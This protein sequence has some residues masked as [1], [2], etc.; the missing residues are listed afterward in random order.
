M[1]ATNVGAELRQYLTFSLAGEEYAVGILE[2]KE[3][4]A[5][6]V[7]TKVP[8]TPCWI[9]GVI[10]LRGA[11]VPV[12]D[13]GLKFGLE[14]RPVGNTTCI[15]VLDGLLGEHN[16]TMGIVVDA[17][18][19][20]LDL[21]TSDIHQPPVFGTRVAPDYLVGMVRLGQKF[22]LILDAGKVLSTDELLNMREVWALA[23][24]LKGNDASM[25]AERRTTEAGA[26]TPTEGEETQ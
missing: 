3:I 4:I 14:E 8:K 20:V 7:V 16:A 24:D 18:N 21:S 13:L 25:V 9:S 12:V 11:V 23:E 1:E 17:V 5:Y 22:A 15:I 6:D 10:N 2:I 26:G 19:Q